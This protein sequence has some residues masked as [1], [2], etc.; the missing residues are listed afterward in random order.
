M[1]LTEDSLRLNLTRLFTSVGQHPFDSIDWERRDAR[2]VDHRTG[3]ASFEQL[4]IEV[5]STWSVNATNIVAQKYFRGTLGTPGREDSVRQL[6][7]RVVDTITRWGHDGGYFAD[8][9]QGEIFR[10]ELLSILVMQRAAFNSP[11][12]FNIGVDG[13]PNQSSACFILSVEDSVDSILEWVREEGVIFKGGSGA[14]VN[15]SRIRASTERLGGGGTPSGPVSFMR[16]ADSSAGTIKSGGKTRRAA[17]MVILDVDH[18]DIEEFIWCKAKEE[19]KARVLRAAGFDMDLDGADAVSIQY[20][21]A[22]NSV[23]VP[24]GFMEAVLADGEWD[25]TA[26]T[27]GEVLETVRAT[28][29][30]DAIAGAAWDCADPG[31]QFDT[32]INQWHTTPA[33]GRINGSNPCFPGSARVHTDKGLVRFDELFSRVSAGEE[34]NVWTHDVTDPLRPDNRVVLSTPEAFMITGRNPIVRLRFS[35]GGELRCTPGHRIFTANRGFVAAGDLTSDD[36]VRLADLPTPAPRADR[37]LPAVIDGPDGHR[38]RTSWT[39]ELA[40][41]VGRIAGGATFDGST[42]TMTYRPDEVMAGL[43]GRHSAALEELLGIVPKVID[44]DDGSA[45]IRLVDGA[46]VRW[47]TA[48]GVSLGADDARVVPAAC[49]ELPDDLAIEALGA[50]LGALGYGRDDAMSAES[51]SPAL[52]RGIQR[53]LSAVGVVSSIA[54]TRP[55][56]GLRSLTVD[57]A[58]SERFSPVAAAAGVESCSAHA[59]DVQAI[60]VATLLER[61]DAESKIYCYRIRITIND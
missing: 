30:M 22:N 13:V 53:M 23:R 16:G 47:L 43:C 17:K 8:D 35:N 34:F 46:V 36:F 55:S 44:R 15:L 29:V 7:G 58:N 3:V 27:N 5:P 1:S 37:A 10:D 59:Q 40:H 33:S 60:V 51:R 14:G 25:L 57:I 50:M 26:R 54:T 52:L 49:F 19:R 41:L 24:D 38:V 9:E 39:P 11:V 12:W 48:L 56:S 6:I 28:D 20:Q 2:L 31:M 45:E 32:T 21:N 18:P 4:G 61:T 42:M